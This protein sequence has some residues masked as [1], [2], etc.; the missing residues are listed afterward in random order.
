[1]ECPYCKTQLPKSQISRWRKRD[2]QCPGCGSAL[3]SS[4]DASGKVLV[5]LFA[6][7]IVAKFRIWIVDNVGAGTFLLILLGLIALIGKECLFRKVEVHGKLDI[8]ATSP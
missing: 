7:M 5:Y 3:T 8:E 6:G 4:P 1:M 2:F